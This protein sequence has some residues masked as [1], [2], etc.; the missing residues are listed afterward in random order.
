[1][2]SE[3]WIKSVKEIMCNAAGINKPKRYN[4]KYEVKMS[5]AAHTDGTLRHATESER[6]KRRG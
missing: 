1:M 5:E 2:A 6:T 4:N 3:K